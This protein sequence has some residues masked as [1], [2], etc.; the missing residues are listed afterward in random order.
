MVLPLF[1]ISFTFSVYLLFQ[2]ETLI[3]QLK[4]FL[5]ALLPEKRVDRAVYIGRMAGEMFSNFLAGQCTEAVILEQCSL[6]L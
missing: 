1:F 6:S 3:R 2:K 5:Y 4:K